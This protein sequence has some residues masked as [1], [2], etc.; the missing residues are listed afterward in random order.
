MFLIKGYSFSFDRKI[1]GNTWSTCYLS[2]NCIS[3]AENNRP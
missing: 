1:W 2:V 3:Q